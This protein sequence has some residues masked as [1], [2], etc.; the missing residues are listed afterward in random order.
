MNI[1][2]AYDNSA[3]TNAAPAGF[4]QAVQAAVNYLDNLI[5]DPIT[6]KIVFSYGELQNQA[7]GPNTLGESQGNGYFVSYA[8]MVQALAATASSADDITSVLSLPSDPTAGTQIFLSDAQA[9]ALGFGSNPHFI[10][11]EDGFVA[12]TNSYKL[13]YDPNNRAVSG[14]YDAVGIL[15]HEITEVLGRT[16]GLGRE[17]FNNTAFYTPLDMFRYSAPG[18]HS[19]SFTS[20][21]FSVDGSSLLYTF[22]DP[23][24]GGDIGDWASGLAGDS[25]GSGYLG[26][27][28][29]VSSTDTRLMDLLGYKLSTT[30]VPT[31]TMTGAQFIGRAPIL[32]LIVNPY[33]VVLTDVTVGNLNAVETSTHVKAVSIS[34]QSFAVFPFLT[35]L[36]S[37]S[38]VV[39]ITVTD[40]NPYPLSFNQYLAD[41]AAF[42]RVSGAYSLAV[43][44]VPVAG[45]LQVEQDP[46]LSSLWINDS[47]A[48]VSAAFDAL[49]SD[50]LVTQIQL[51]DGAATF[52][53][54]AAPLTLTALQSQVD[55]VALGKMAA[56]FNMVVTGGAGADVAHGASGD[57]TLAGGAGADTLTGG[58]GNDAFVFAPGTGADV[59][60]DFTA[61]G[62]N[63]S[64]NLS[65]Y[66]HI[67]SFEEVLAH[68]VQSGPDTIVKLGEEDQVTL[69]GVSRGA[70]TTADVTL[71]TAVSPDFASGADFT[72]DG[73]GDVLWRDNTGLVALWSF[74]PGGAV[75]YAG[76]DTVGP[77]WHIQGAA[78]FT[79][80]GKA[81]VLWRND[82]GFM[83]LWESTPSG[84]F[85]YVGLGQVG[86]N[87]H[88]QAAADFTGDGKADVLWRDDT[89][90]MAM[91]TSNPSNAALTYASLG[92]VG[93]NWHVQ[94][95]GDFNGDGKA[96]VLWRDDTGLVAVWES[97]GLG[98]PVTYVGLNPAGL[99]WSIAGTGDFNGD[100]KADI[101]WRQDTGRVALWESGPSS[102]AVN[103]VDLG[104]VGLDWHVQAVGD[105]NH[106]G[107]ADVLWRDD[108][109]R[110]ATWDSTPGGIA[111]HDFG[112]V[113]ASWFIS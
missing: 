47:A 20:A 50:G 46:H 34:D 49:N 61:G 90:L 112:I 4:Q 32:S 105:F 67:G 56:P 64:I 83:A 31:L 13:T 15:E 103:Y 40:S 8:Q 28:S 95:A 68:A 24:N 85:S 35:S 75:S 80:D 42:A 97:N 12:L 86:L 93:L 92:Q 10:D 14:A 81:D 45:R 62:T 87:W 54:P 39:S 94:G 84:Q 41:G 73:A 72:G 52:F 99:D 101:L 29:Q 65:A 27:A 3:S 100:G 88:V 6:V 109:G 82:S 70:L 9:K 23:N 53:A 44:N 30:S 2:I 26:M 59:I 16:G 21:S 19:F 107:K 43:G 63:D 111:Y 38:L 104:V 79:G 66:S 106:D 69:S 55:T 89:G 76:I 110:T 113:G 57:D 108:S 98:S 11:P 58:S 78:D 102:L 96:D 25:F 77:T 48:N 74:A 91:W 22:N 37:D 60:T 7:F 51:T 1:V 18:V 33:N 71:A 5:A 36:A 17:T